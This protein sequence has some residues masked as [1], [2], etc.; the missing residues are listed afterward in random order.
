[1]EKQVIYRDRQEL[2][3]T[4]LDNTQQWGDDALSHVIHDAISGE[5]HYTGMSVS[6]SSA[7][8]LNI[9]A[10][11][12]YDGSDGRV[13]TIDAPQIKSVFGLLPLQD[14]KWL[15]VSVVGQEIETNLEP[16]DFLVDL[17][18]REVEPQTV[19]MQRARVA[20]VH[21]AQGLESPTP[22]KPEPPTGYTLIAQVRLNSSGIQEI[23]LAET[24]RLPNLHQ[25]AGRLGT[26][27]GWITTAEPRIAHIQSDI[28]G[29]ADGLNRRAT[30]EQAIQLGM[31]MAKVKERLEL[32]DDYVFY[33]ADHYLDARETD[34]SPAD[35]SA[36]LDEGIRFAPGA[37]ATSQL[38]IDNPLDGAASL[39][40]DGFLLPRFDEQPRLR[41][42]TRA[43]E[44]TINQ[45]QYQTVETVRRTMTRQRI[46]YGATRTVCTNS[47][48]W[49]SGNYDIASGIFSK[50]GE[51]F[52]V[53][54]DHGNRDGPG[55][56]TH[57]VRITQ[58]WADDYE[59]PY[60]DAETTTHTVQGSIIGQT[61]LSAQTGWHTSAELYFTSVANDGAV[62]V[63][64]TA[65][66]NG[67]PNM[68]RVLAAATLTADGLAA[69][70]QRIPWDRP[71]FIEAGKRYALVVT[72]G[73]A[74]RVGFAKGTE[75]TQGIL[76][77]SQDREFF[78]EASDRDLMMRLNFAKFRAPRV[79]IQLK[80]LEL[81]GGI[82]DIDMLFQGFTPDGTELAFEYRIGGVWYTIEAGTAEALDV[83]PA[84]LPLRVVFTGTTDLM[85]GLQLNGSQ[86][87]LAQHGTAFRHYSTERTLDT[88]SD[89][90]IV[91]T[92]VEDYVP[93]VHTVDVALI[94]DGTAVAATGQ[95][96]ERVDGRSHWLESR[97]T[98]D[99]PATAYA[100]RIDG[101]TTD[102]FVGFH[103]AERYDIAL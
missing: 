7:T 102:P 78:I 19:A 1:M 55:G 100:I 12:L 94:V 90:L 42:E 22:E 101:A 87:K 5:R 10:G 71:V 44:M 18:T 92:L 81:A 80:A 30:I 38:A 96:T 36:Y 35:Y 53:K 95:I 21:I 40:D 98:L 97:F 37:T 59:E 32:P 34:D 86:V 73:G 68:D 46:R 45:Y 27:E 67:Q 62:T 41:L 74:H 6:S 43:G 70:W 84:L 23:V 52:E 89:T 56:L 69:G 91:R 31:D 9:A 63:M 4:D 11:R 26:V 48:F 85:P 50:D 79:A 33:G 39:S 24:R 51:T 20:E 47:S 16:R 65:V 83:S 61:F 72:S 17:Q 2:Q 60:W 25:V 82:H 75:Y 54:D 57:W 15:A 28:A 88:P 99:A 103:V 8:E 58:F 13:Y 64:L 29:L 3:A 76:C 93:D 77:Y 14:E 66:K 49:R